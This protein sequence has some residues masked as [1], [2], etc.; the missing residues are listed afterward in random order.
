MKCLQGEP[1]VPPTKQPKYSTGNIKH[2]KTCRLYSLCKTQAA[3]TKTKPKHIPAPPPIKKPHKQTTSRSLGKKYICHFLNYNC[4]AQTAEAALWAHPRC[5]CW[6]HNLP[7]RPPS[8][9]SCPKVR[10]HRAKKSTWTD[11]KIASYYRI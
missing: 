6:H 4:I 3:S 5:A 9:Q 11:H 8:K 2:L 7:I 10:T 1:D